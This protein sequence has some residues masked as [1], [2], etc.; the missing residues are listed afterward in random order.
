[1]WENSRLGYPVT[2]EVCGLRDGGCFVHFQGGSVYSGAGYGPHAINGAIRDAWAR[3]GWENGLGYPTTDEVCGLREGGCFQH[4]ERGSVYSSPGTG[5][6]AVLSD[7]R[8]P[9]ARAG[10]ENGFGYPTTDRV[11]GLRE[12]GCFQHFQR[13][14]V[15]VSPVYG[16]HAVSGVIRDT[17]ARAG[18]ENGLGYPTNDEFVRGG[19]RVQT[20][21]RG[22]VTVDL[23]TG[24][25]QV[26]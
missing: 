1:G 23:A 14:S 5:A 25:V 16:A 6:R 19:A 21:Q 13:G 12:G 26:L 24:R 4:F 9:W 8:D 7:I 17:W 22:R 10:W 20:F 15:Y 11:C 2:D 3:A 18:W